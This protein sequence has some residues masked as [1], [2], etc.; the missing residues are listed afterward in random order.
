[1]NEQFSKKA[2]AWSARFS[3]PVSDLVKRYTASVFFDKRLAMFDIQGSLAHAEMLAAQGI[4]SAAD[5]AEI[6]RGMAQIRAEIEAGSFEWLLDLE[7]VHLNIEKRLTE[8]VGDA[9]KRL[10]TGRSRNDQVATDIRLYV[11]AAIDDVVALLQ[12]LRGALTNLAE[13]HFDTIMP[14]F[15]HLQVAQP[16]TFGHHMLA[17]VEMFGRDAERMLDARRRVNRLPLG[18]AAQAGPPIPIDRQRGANTLGFEDVCHNSLDAVS[19]RDFAIEFTA[20]ASVLMM[21]V[22]RMSEELVMWMSPRVGFIDIADR[23]CTGSS[24][25]PQ[26]KNPDVPEL[27]RGKTGRVYGHLTALLTLMKGQP[28]A[29][30]KDNQEDKEPLFDTVDTVLDTLRIFTDMAGG[31]TLNMRAAALQGYATATD[32]ADY[33]VKKGLPFRDAHEAVAHAVRA[34]DDAQCDLSEMSLER[35]REFSPLIEDDVFAVLTLEGSVAARDHVGGTA[36]NQVRKAIERV[37]G[38]LKG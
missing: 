32:L 14:G 15:T 7:D 9:G 8:L 20:A 11:R 25:M 13:R 4:I 31:I 17:Y 29:Y 30:N 34:C 1:M 24:I 26:K 5:R 33:L 36:P 37:R 3:E 18:A 2:E 23:F 19:D 16:I 10:H 21:H 35:L 12:Q 28:L 22:S 27:A 6:E 38:Q